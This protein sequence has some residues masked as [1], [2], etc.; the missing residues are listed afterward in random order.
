MDEITN[1]GRDPTLKLS[2]TWLSLETWGGGSS[3]PERVKLASLVTCHSVTVWQCDSMSVSH[4]ITHLRIFH[5]SLVLLTPSLY[6]GL[7]R[8]GSARDN[9][10]A[11]LLLAG[12]VR[13]VWRLVMGTNYVWHLEYHKYLNRLRPQIPQPWLDNKTHCWLV[14]FYEW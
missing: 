1:F 9:F 11:N 6:R 3:D 7:S 2:S 8:S 4:Y 10:P 12:P 13:A 14:C 5:H